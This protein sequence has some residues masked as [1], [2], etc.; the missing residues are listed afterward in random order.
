MEIRRAELLPTESVI[1]KRN[2]AA[3][4][5]D[6]HRAGNSEPNSIRVAPSRKPKPMRSQH[7]E[8][9][10]HPP[11]RSDSASQHHFQ[12]P[13]ETPMAGRT[14]HSFR[15]P[16]P[17]DPAHADLVHADP[18]APADEFSPIPGDLQRKLSSGWRR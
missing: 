10:P 3:A 18:L 4:R 16:V 2:R 8:T 17:S 12:P 9:V 11:A 6:T 13:A 7:S 1:L 15:D 14:S 5:P